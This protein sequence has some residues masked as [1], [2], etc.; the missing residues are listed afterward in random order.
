MPQNHFR[1]LLRLNA[2]QTLSLGFA[3]L[4]LAGGLLLTLPFASRDGQSIPFLN[5]LFTAASASCVTGL[6]LYDTYTQFSL[7]GQ[8]VILLLIQIGGMGFMSLSILFSILLHRRI[9][10][11]ERSILMDSV[12][13]LQMGGVVRLTRRAIRVT[14]CLEGGGAALLALWF[15]PRYGLGRG[16]WMSVFHAVS[17]FC[18][19]GFDILGTGSSLAVMAGDPLPNV[20]IMTL[21]AAGGLG[22]LVWDDILTHRRHVRRWRLHSKIVVVFTSALFAGGAAAFYFLEGNHAF[23]GATFG[24]KILMAAFQ[25]VTCR[26]A[27]FATADLMKLSA[28]AQVRRK[29]DVNIFRRRLDEETIRRAYSSVSMF[30]LACL[31]GCMV[32]CAQGITLD[33]AL[34]EAISAIGTVGLTRGVTPRLPELSKLVVLLLMFSGRVGSMSVA[35]AVTRDRPQAKLRNVPEKILIG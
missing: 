26:T 11:H 12:G 20:V 30:F 34:F 31:A 27:G 24:Q 15:L 28:L 14:F 9:G 2:V 23:A 32:L 3:A 35:M 25:S 22:F 21:I 10:L 19:A 16:L 33:G 8:A 29:Q 18:N 17:A 5:A 7:F 13:A 1:K 4:I 6:S